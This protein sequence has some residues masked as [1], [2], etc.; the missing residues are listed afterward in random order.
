MIPFCD[1]I[2]WMLSVDRPKVGARQDGISRCGQ[3]ERFKLHS[4]V[5][6]ITR[7]RFEASVLRGG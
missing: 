6:W 4:E 7:Y 3:L 2:G 5:E 1:A